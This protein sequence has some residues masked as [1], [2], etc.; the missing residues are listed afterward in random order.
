[1]NTFWE[2]L[3]MGWHHV[4]DL[5]AYDHVLFFIALTLPYTF[6]NW[7]KVVG[8]VSVFTIG[9]STAMFLSSY[10]V[11]SINQNIAEILIPFSIFITALYHLITAGKNTKNTKNYGVFG[12]TMFFGTIHGLAF[13]G[14]IR[15]LTTSANFDKLG[16]LLQFGL[17]IECAQIVVVFVSL[18]IAYLSTHLLKISKRDYA[19]VLSSLIIGVI[20]PMLFKNEI[21]M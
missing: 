19:L 3:K 17:G 9:H 4:I 21:F 20:L 10:N 18:I 13:A 2:Y 6:V 1:M 11:I 16:F 12:L 15:V 14:D 5:E 8:L 7:R